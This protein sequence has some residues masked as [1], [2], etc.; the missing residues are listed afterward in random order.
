MRSD[1]FRFQQGARLRHAPFAGIGMEV[2]AISGGDNK[3][4]T[5]GEI[6]EALA[7]LPFRCVSGENR[8]ERGNDARVIEVL[9]IELVHTR[10][11]EGRA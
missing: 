6:A 4:P 2:G 3:A 9:G 11:V 5:D 7:L 10:S 8:I 1:E